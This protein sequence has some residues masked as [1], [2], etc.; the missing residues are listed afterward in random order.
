MLEHG[1]RR[2]LSRNCRRR[3]RGSRRLGL[4]HIETTTCP[5][6]SGELWRMLSSVEKSA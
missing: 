3:H 6:T 5:Q 2:L 1:I 4:G